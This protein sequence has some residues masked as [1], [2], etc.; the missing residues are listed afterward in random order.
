MIFNT[1]NP[2]THDCK[3]NQRG[4]QDA[5]DV[6]KGK[7]TVYVIG[8]L[9]LHGKSRFNEMQRAIP[10]IT[11]KMLSKELK[12]L[13]VNKLLKRTVIDSMP[14][15]VEYELTEY[16]S[17]LKTVISEITR[18]GLEHRKVIMQP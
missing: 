17:T 9:V 12:D 14:V 15:A 7:W 8:H 16:G 4:M 2:N 6:L 10:G 3:T 13:E 5:L 1:L 11:S 18:W